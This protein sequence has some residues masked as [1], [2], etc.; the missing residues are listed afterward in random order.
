MK[1]KNPKLIFHE[2]E[3]LPH[4]AL[5]EASGISNR[6]PRHVHFSYI[7][8]LIDQGKCR[9]NFNSDTITFKAGELCILPPGTAHSCETVIS[10]T[11]KQHSYRALCVKA[12][13]M[14]KLSAE[15]CDRFCGEPDF[16]P[17]RVYTDYDHTSFDELF[18]LINTPGTEPEK[19]A[20]LD[21]F[22]YQIIETHSCGKIIAQKTGPQHG[23]LH[24]V[25]N[26]IDQNFQQKL[27]L[28]ELAQTA[29]LSPFHLQKLFV[30]KYG[31]SPQEYI[32]FKRVLEARALIEN[33]TPLIEAALKSGFSDQS[34]F[35]RHFK[36][37]IGI[38]PGQFLKENG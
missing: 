18:A 4:V 20:A 13:Y 31:R 2:P 19:Q 26:F 21:S 25:K 7:F 3:G 28:Q 8:T 38:S 23:A 35:S 24:R 37:V 14:A 5:V 22:L 15:I 16:D 32:I 6:F 33:N 11:S 36:K 29:C 30:N 12:Q 1:N 9:I 34:H 10:R 27:T 17:I